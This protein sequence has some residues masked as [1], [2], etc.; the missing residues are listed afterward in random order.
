MRLEAIALEQLGPFSKPVRIEGIGPGLN[1]LAGANEL[2]KSTLLKGLTALFTEQYQTKRKAIRDLRPYAGGAPF[3]GCSFELGGHGWRLEKRFLSAQTARLQRRDGGEEHQGADAE[4]RLAELLGADTGLATALPLLWVGQGAGMDIPAVSDGVRQTLGQMLAAEA[5]SAAGV[6][7]AQAVLAAVKKELDQLVTE[8]TGRARR[9]GSYDKLITERRQVSAALEAARQK[10]RDAQ[11]RLGRLDEL[12]RT[13]AELADKEALAVHQTRLSEHEARL[14]TGREA[15]RQLQQ[16]HERVAFLD[17]QHQQRVATLTDHDEGLVERDKIA[18]AMLEANDELAGIAARLEG[19]DAQLIATGD[20]VASSGQREAALRG[21]LDQLRR[22]EAAAQRQERLRQLTS[23]RERLAA[24]ATGIEELDVELATLAW[25]ETLMA[26]LRSASLRLEQARARQ[27]A[28]APRVRFAYEAG[29]QTGFRLAG[30]DVAD[31]TDLLASGPLTIEVAGIGRIEVIPGPQETL[32]ALAHEM[33]TAQADFTGCLAAMGATDMA[34]AEARE[35]HRSELRNARQQLMSERDGLAP[36]GAERLAREAQRLADDDAKTPEGPNAP[37]AAA[38]E[39]SLPDSAEDLAQALEA[40]TAAGGEAAA[41][42]D[43]LKGE[44][45]EL[46]QRRAAIAAELRVHRTRHGELDMKYARADGEADPRD[47]LEAQVAGAVQALNAAARDRLAVQEV[48]LS[49]TAL[50]D[51]EQEIKTQRGAIAQ[52]AER[53]ATVQ[54]EMRHT[55]GMLAQSFED[56]S[57]SD[58]PELEDRLSET[59]KRL[60]AAERHI[61]ALRLLAEELELETSQRRDA[62]ARPLAQRMTRLAARIWPD[63]AVPFSADLTVDGVTRAGQTEAADRISAGTRE[64]IAVLARLAY[65]GLLSQVTETVPVILDD[66]L[67]FSDDD[68]LDVL[69]STLADE[70]TRQQIIVLTCHERAFEPLVTHYGATRLSLAEA[71]AA[72]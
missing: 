17:S 3:V 49:Q 39:T 16:L 12:Q 42:L 34:D 5:D 11:E 70:A 31:G 28:S 29:R 22:A 67:V 69:F 4:N 68:R 48:A 61:A 55:E 27:E 18:T 1:V 36:E 25:P 60:R 57:G 44:K 26:D 58:V 33:T 19:I 41:A 50:A 46:E 53:L 10:A 38:G 8:R 51:L 72:A 21:R 20:A 30:G 47:D 13:A 23:Q 71:C 14:Q 64:Q 9:H 2:G 66:P 37:N 24:I 45:S 52:R 62:I 65:A 40:A 35:Q 59:G 32:E 15:Q 6:G 7:Q 63:V 43:R 54:Q 56:G